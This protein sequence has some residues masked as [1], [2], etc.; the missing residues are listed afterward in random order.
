MNLNKVSKEL[1][2]N[3]S[4]L[5]KQNKQNVIVSANNFN[6]IKMFLNKYK[7]N[8]LPYRFANCF[9]LQADMDD[10]NILSNQNDVNFFQILIKPFNDLKKFLLT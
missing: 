5:G 3:V 9:C 6:N 2:N 1:I 10:V 7:Y 8:Y 4:I